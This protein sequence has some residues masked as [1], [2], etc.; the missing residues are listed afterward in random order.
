MS[1]ATSWA[2]IEFPVAA[3]D[4]EIKGLLEDWGV[5][6]DGLTPILHDDDPRVENEG[7]IFNLHHGDVN[8][9]EFADLEAKLKE[10]A[11]PFDRM[12]GTDW[13]ISPGTRIYR[14]GPPEFDHYYP[15]DDDG[16]VVVSVE[17]IRELLAL[18]DAGEEAA[19]N[20]KHYL[21]EHFP[22]Y[23]SLTDYVKEAG[24]HD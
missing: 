23:P 12:T 21:D 2:T 4:E 14:P 9:G 7:G 16:E 6:F 19:S 1:S 10:Q 15:Q 18:D 3:I 24:N 8:Y 17:K 5:E 11:I 13:N 20:I 22:T